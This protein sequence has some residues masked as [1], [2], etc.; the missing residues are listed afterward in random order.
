[1]KIRLLVSIIALTLFAGCTSVPTAPTSGQQ[2]AANAV[3]DLISIGLVPVLSK[4][5]AY[6]PE[7]RVLASGLGLTFKGTELTPA[8]VDY[9][10]SK[11][12]ISPADAKVISGTVNAAWSVFCKRYAAQV[13]ASVR[14]DLRL[15]L[16]AVSNG[17]NNA[18]AA[19]PKG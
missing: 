11:T 4:N 1:M 16:T 8:D 14:P 13:S 9:Y 12:D 7:A 6:L 15:F 18:I 17:I 2:L 3:E 5:P 19:V 10:L